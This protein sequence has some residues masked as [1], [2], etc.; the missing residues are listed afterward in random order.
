MALVPQQTG[1]VR[2][3]WP[4]VGA[5]VEGQGKV[6]GLN[7]RGMPIVTPEGAILGHALEGG[8]TVTITFPLPE[9]PASTS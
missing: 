2:K 7:G 3:E 6:T 8:T 5:V 1:Q 4:P 9:T